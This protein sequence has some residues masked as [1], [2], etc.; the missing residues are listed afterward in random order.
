MPQEHA[1]PAGAGGA[2]A[3]C[4]GATAILQVTSDK[5]PTNPLS[6]SSSN[7]TRPAA[8]TA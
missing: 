4:D 8:V 1:P 5:V 7:A 3:S 6:S 2:L